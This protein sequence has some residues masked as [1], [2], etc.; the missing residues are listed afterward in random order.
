MFTTYPTS[1]ESLYNQLIYSYESDSTGDIE[2]TVTNSANGSDSYVKKLY[3]TSS[4]SI[5]I[6]PLFRYSSIPQL[7]V[8]TPSIY[9]A[10][11]G[12]AAVVAT[13]EGNSTSKGIFT[14]SKQ[15]ITTGNLMTSMPLSRLIAVGECDIIRIFTAPSEAVL[16]QLYGKSV[17]EDGEDELITQYR[18][19]DSHDGVL[20]LVFECPDVEYQELSLIIYHSSTYQTINYT[21]TKPYNIGENIRLAWLSSAG[22]IEHHTFPIVKGKSLNR[23]GSFSYTLLSAYAPD[24]YIEAIAEIVS[25]AAVWIVDNEEYRRVEVESDIAPI[26]DCGSLSYLELKIKDNG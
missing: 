1:G 26:K 21:L 23:D 9:P 22:S 12:Y 7:S 25:S 8:R 20:E 19:I 24:S 13:C 10:S 14:L 11:D 15:S 17:D 18:M 6:A 5:N 16:A 3:D 2:L 4:V